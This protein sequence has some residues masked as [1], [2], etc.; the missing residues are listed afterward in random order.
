MA[1][2]SSVHVSS[3]PYVSTRQAITSGWLL[4]GALDILAAR[5]RCQIH[6]ARR[7]YA[8]GLHQAY[9]VGNV[10]RSQAVNLLLKTPNSPAECT[11]AAESV[12]ST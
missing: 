2:T 1:V 4:C 6:A 3:F 7:V 9:R 5:I 12:I 11:V 8:P 10:L